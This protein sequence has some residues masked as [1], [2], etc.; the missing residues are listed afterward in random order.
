[1]SS[2]LVVTIDTAAPGAPVISTFGDDTGVQGDALT[3]DTTITLS[4]SSEPNSMVSVFDGATLLGTAVA[5][6][7]GAWSY[8]T[9]ALPDG[10]HVFS[11]KATDAAG[12]QSGSSQ[13]FSVRIDSVAPAAPSTPTVSATLNAE[14]FWVEGVAEAGALVIVARGNSVLGS[15]QLAPGQ[16]AYSIPVPLAQETVNLL[17]VTA[18]DAAGN[19]SVATRV[20]VTEVPSLP[21]IF[22]VTSESDAD[23]GLYHRGT[24]RW[25]INQANASAG[26][27]IIRFNI[28]GGGVRTITPATALPVLEGGITIDGYSQP[29][30]SANTANIDEAFNGVIA[31][32][33]AGGNFSTLQLNGQNYSVS[34]LALGGVTGGNGIIW[35]RGSGIAVSGNFIGLGADGAPWGPMSNYGVFVSGGYNTIGGSVPAQRNIVGNNQQGVGVSAGESTRITGNFIGVGPSGTVSRPNGMGIYVFGNASKTI[36]GTNSDG[37]DDIQERN[38]V[39]GNT[40]MGI[41]V[42][43]SN[44]S[45]I[46]GN[47][48]GLTIKGTAALANGFWGIG[49][50][51]AVSATV[52]SNIVSGNAQGGIYVRGA[53]SSTNI[54][55]QNIV[56]LAAD[57][58]TALGNAYSGITLNDWGVAGDGPSDTQVVGNIVASNREYG[59]WTRGAKNSIIRGNKV[60][61]DATGLK[62]SGNTSIGVSVENSTGTMIGGV[63]EADGNLISG[64]NSGGIYVVS[65]SNTT[66]SANKVGTNRDGNAK[67]ANAAWGIGV[68]NSPN[69]VIGGATASLGNLVSGNSQGGIF[70]RGAT[71]TSVSIRNNL[72]GTA[73]NGASALGNAFSGIAIVD[74][75]VAND[76]PSGVI[77]SENT[78]SAN[79]QYGIWIDGVS[80]TGNSITRN[81]VGVT[82]DGAGALSN[83]S[84]AIYINQSSGNSIGGTS[85]IEGNT[86]SANGWN[87]ILVAG[88]SASGNLVSGNTITTSGASGVFVDSAVGTS[89]RLNTIEAPGYSGVRLIGATGGSQVSSNTIRNAG[90]GVSISGSTT[91]GLSVEGNQISQVATG[92]S[93]A[94]GSGISVFGNSLG[95]V[96]ATG[97]LFSSVKSGSSV[98]HNS[99]NGI[100]GKGIVLENSSSVGVSGNNLSAIASTGIVISG[101]SGVELSASPGDYAIDILSSSLSGS[102]A[103][104][105]SG[106][107]YLSAPLGNLVSFSTGVT[108][109]SA[110]VVRVSGAI[111]STSG[112][113]ILGDGDT[114]VVLEGDTA[115]DSGTAATILGGAVDGAYSLTIAGSGANQIVSQ[116]GAVV[117]LAAFTTGATGTISVSGII[118]TGNIVLGNHATVSGAIS[119]N[120]GGFTAKAGLSAPND[121]RINSPAGTIVLE[122]KVAVAGRAAFKAG[123]SVT[124]NNTANQF[125]D[126][127]TVTAPSVT[128]AA[129]GSISAEL[130]ATNATI[131]SGSNAIVA[132]SVSGNLDVTASGAINQ[133]GPLSVGQRAV[134]SARST[135]DIRLD[136]ANNFQTLAVTQ[137]RNV[138]VRD[139][140]AITLGASFIAG[141]LSVSAGGAVSADALKVGG[142]ASFT[143][144]GTGS[145]SLL[146]ANDFASLEFSVGGDVTV[147]DVN[148][149][150]LVGG[151][152]GGNLDVESAGWLSDSGLVTV[153]GNASLATGSMKLANFAVAGAVGIQSKGQA[154]VQNATSLTVSSAS[155]LGDL[156][157]VAITGNISNQGPVTVSGNARLA[158][159]SP[160]GTI[161]LNQV[162]V[163]GSVAF[164]SAG[165]VFLQSS[166]PIQL[167]ESIIAGNLAVEGGDSIIQGGSL[168]VTGTSK[169]SAPGKSV[170]LFDSGNDFRGMVTVTAGPVAILASGDLNLMLSTGSATVDAGGKLV[171]RGAV[172]GALSSKSAGELAQSGPLVV[173]ADATITA[174]G[175]SVTLID[176]GN[177][178]RGLVTVTAGP[179]AIRGSGDLNLSLS[180]GSATVDAGGKL[181]IRGVVSGALSSKSTG[182]VSQSG[183]LVVTGDA[184]ITAPSQSVSLFDSGNDFRGMVTVTAGPVGI[185]ASG[186]LNVSL[187]TGSATVDAGGKLVIRGVVSGALSSKSAGPVSQSGPLMVT[188]DATITAPGKSV[189]LNNTGNDFQGLTSV[190]AGNVEIIDSNSLNVVVNASR[191]DLHAFGNLQLTG[192]VGGDLFVSNGVGSSTSVG[193]LFVGG[194]MDLKSSGHVSN[195]GPVTI[196][197]SAMVRIGAQGNLSLS[198]FNRF[199]FLNI[200][201][202]NQVLVSGAML[203]GLTVSSASSVTLSGNSVT[204]S[205]GVGIEVVSAGA[206]I[207]SGNLVTGSAKSGIVVANSA[208]VDV[209]DNAVDFSGADGIALQASPGS[210]VRGNTVTKAGGM[211]IRLSGISGATVSGNTIVSPGLDGISLPG[212]DQPNRL[213]GNTFKGISPGRLFVDVGAAG[214]DSY[215]LTSLANPPVLSS[216]VSDVQGIIVSGT[217]LGRPNTATTI[218]LFRTGAGGAAEPSGALTGATDSLGV[219]TFELVV[220]GG[221]QGNGFRAIATSPTQSSEMSPELLDGK[222]LAVAVRDGA[223]Q[224]VMTNEPY[225]GAVRFVV[226]DPAGSVVPFVPVRLTLPAAG[227]SSAFGDGATLVRGIYGVR[228]AFVVSDAAGVATAPSIKAGPVAGDFA[229]TAMVGQGGGVMTTAGLEIRPPAPLV[230][231]AVVPG[232]NLSDPTAISGE[233]YPGSLVRIYRAGSGALVASSQLSLGQSSFS[234]TLPVAAENDRGERWIVTATYDGS[235]AN[236]SDQTAGNESNSRPIAEAPFREL[237]LNAAS[238]PV[239]GAVS[240]GASVAISRNTKALTATSA[241]YL[242]VATDFATGAG[243]WTS[244][245]GGGVVH[246]GADQVDDGSLSMLASAP[247]GPRYFAAPAAYLGNK[248]AFLGGSLSFSL[249]SSVPGAGPVDVIIQGAG[250]T[251][252]RVVGVQPGVSWRNYSASFLPDGTWRVGESNGQAATRDQ[253]ALVLGSLESLLIRGTDDAGMA[254]FGLDSVAMEGPGAVAY[255]LSLDLVRNTKNQFV[256]VETNRFGNISGTTIL[257]LV[258]EDSIAPRSPAFVSVEG[259]SNVKGDQVLNKNRL[260]L[261]AAADP[262]A[263]PLALASM[264]QAIRIFR[265]GVQVGMVTA[266]TDGSWSFSDPATLPDGVYSYSATATDRAGNE[267]VRSLV[268]KVVVD[269]ANPRS[270]SNFSITPDTGLVGDSVTSVAAP[271]FSG[272][273]EPGS[274]VEVFE[275]QVFLGS[276]LADTRGRW[277]ID[278][279]SLGNGVHVVAV[280]STDLAGNPSDMAFHTIVID[281]SGPA[282]ASIGKII[283]DS[284][285]DSSDGVTNVRRLTLEGTGEPGSFISLTRNGSRFGQAVV[286]TDGIWRFDATSTEL[287]DGTHAFVAMAS[288]LA[289]NQSEATQVFTAVVDTRAPL[290]PRASGITPDTGNPTDRIT[291]VANPVAQGSAEPNARVL[292]FLNSQ[293]IGTARADSLG[294]WSFQLPVLDPGTYSVS[295]RAIDRAGNAS[296]DSLP[297]PVTI[298]SALPA[299][300][301]IT[302][303]S[304]DTG[305]SA[306]DLI[307]RATGFSILGTSTPSLS[308][309]VYRGDTLLG[310]TKATEAGTF[311]LTVSGLAQG[312][313]QFSAESVN[314]AGTNSGRGGALGVRVDTTAPGTPFAIFISDDLGASLSDLLTSDNTLLLGG[315]S[316]SGALVEVQFAGQVRRALADENGKFRVSFED[317]ALADGSYP[318]QILAFDVAG[319]RSARAGAATIRIDTGA[320]ALAVARLETDT[321]TSATDYITSDTTPTLIGTAEAGALVV[322]KIA[323]VNICSPVVADAR[324][325]WVLP[326]GELLSGTYNLQIVATDAAGNSTTANVSLVIDAVS[327]PNATAF[328]IS[329][330]T[331]KPGDFT[332]SSGDVVLSGNAESGALIHVK[333]NGVSQPF[334]AASANSDWSIGIRL[335]VEGDN[336]IWVSVIDA[337]GN[338]CDASSFLVKRDSLAPLAP[339]LSRIS[340]D[341]GFSDTDRVTSA[342]VVTISG[343]A[344]SLSLVSITLN[345]FEVGSTAAAGDGA[346]SF[347]LPSLAASG[348]YA[349]AV[350][351][352]DAAGNLSPLTTFSIVRDA[353]APATAGIDGILDGNILDADGLTANSAPTIRG[354]AEPFARVL[355]AIDNGSFN[356]TTANGDGIWSVV[357]GS[358]ADGIHSVVA[359]VE[360]AAGNRAELS[361]PYFFTIDTSPPVP[362]GIDSVSP[363]HGFSADDG[364]ISS[365]LITVSGHAE[366]GSRLRVRFG[367]FAV[368]D[369][370][371]PADGKWRADFQGMPDGTY[372]LEALTVDIAGNLA[373]AGARAVKVDT[374]APSAPGGL[375][376]DTDTGISTSDGVTRIRPSFLSGKGEAGAR[377]MVS[378]PSLGAEWSSIIGSD[379][380]WKAPI[381]DLPE[382]STTFLIQQTD[383]AGNSSAIANFVVTIDSTVPDRPSIAE[384]RGTVN[385]PPVVTGAPLSSSLPLISGR[386]EA[387]A[388]VRVEVR[389]ATALA[390]S[391]TVLSD[392]GGRWL[393]TPPRALADN[394]YSVTVV[395]IDAAGNESEASSAFILVLDTRAPAAPTVSAV[396]PDTGASSTDN[397]TREATRIVGL[398]EAGARVRFFEILPEG[399]HLLLGEAVAGADRKVELSLPGSGLAHGIHQLIAVAV[400]PAGNTGPESAARSVEVDAI[401]PDTPEIVLVSDDSGLA[402]DGVTN[403]TTPSIS[404]FAEPGATVFVRAGGPDAPAKTAVA[405]EDGSWSVTL[406]LA[407]GRH[408]IEIRAVDRAGN[409]SAIPAMRTLVIDKSA[410]A[411]PSALSV[412]PD[413]GRLATDAITSVNR[414]EISGKSEAGSVV[415]VRCVQVATGAGFEFG[416]VTVGESGAWVVAAPGALDDGKYQFEIDSRDLAGNISAKARLTMIID[417]A[418]PL[419]EISFPANT[420]HYNLK[421]WTGAVKGTAQLLNGSAVA[422][423]TVTVSDSLG[424]HYNGS[425]FQDGHASVVATGTALWSLALPASALSTGLSYTVSVV[426][427]DLAGNLDAPRVVSFDFDTE[428]P[429]PALTAQPAPTNLGSQLLLIDFGEPVRSF[430]MER[431]VASEGLKVELASEDMA[432]GKFTL[433]LTPSREGSFGIKLAAGAVLDLAGNAA[434]AIAF[435]SVF[436]ISTAS[437]N[438]QPL[439]FSAG[440]AGWSG[441]FSQPGDQD[442]F[443]ITAPA[444]G[445]LAISLTGAR[446]LG[447]TLRIVDAGGETVAL[448]DNSS[449]PSSSL[450]A[451]V[452]SGQQLFV[453]AETRGVSSGAYT[454]SMS[455]GGLFIDD[456]GDTAPEAGGLV[457]TGVGTFTLRGEINKAG[458][459]DYFRF[460]APATGMITF[461]AT[462]TGSA[463]LVP[464]LAGGVMEAQFT[465]QSEQESRILGEA[466]IRFP[467]VANIAYLVK[468][469]SHAASGVE[470]SGGYLLESTFVAA[471]DEAIDDQS[472]PSRRIDL[473]SSPLAP[474]LSMRLEAAADADGF[475]IALPQSGGRILIAVAAD[476]PAMVVVGT[477]KDARTFTV[478]NGQVLAEGVFGSGK[479]VPVR[480]FTNGQAGGAYSVTAALDERPSTPDEAPV[481]DPGPTGQVISGLAIPLPGDVDFS[482]I[483]ARSNGKVIVRLDPVGE[484]FGAGLQVVSSSG[485]VLGSGGL[486]EDFSLQATATVSA[487]QTVF[488]RVIGANG[489]TGQYRLALRQVPDDFADEVG[490]ATPLSGVSNGTLDYTSDR[491]FFVFTASEAGPHLVRAR[492]VAG[493]RTEP[494]LSVYREGF[495]TPV[496]SVD[497]EAPDANGLVT[498]DLAAGER[499]F[500]E[501]AGLG[502]L[503]RY[504]VQAAPDRV[505]ATDDHPDTINQGRLAGPGSR[506]VAGTATTGVISPESDADYLG[507]SLTESGRYTLSADALAGA[508]LDPRLALFQKDSAGSWHLLAS[509]DDGGEGANALI[510]QAL[511]PGEYLARVA[512]SRGTAGAYRVGLTRFVTQAQTTADDAPDS[513][514]QARAVEFTGI[515]NGEKA[516]VSARIDRGA[517]LDFFSLTPS[518]D[519][520]LVISVAAVSG[521][522]DPVLAY[523]SGSENLTNDNAG[524]GIL[525]SRIL[526]EA[527]AGRPIILSVASFGLTTGAYTL[528]ATVLERPEDDHGQTAA[529]AAILRG[530]SLQGNLEYAGDRDV[531]RYEP[532]F[533]GILTI[534]LNTVSGVAN[535]RL[536]ILDGQGS[537]LAEDVAGGDG[538]NSLL[539]ARVAAGTPLFIESS[540]ALGETG[541]YRLAVDLADDDFGND[542]AGAFALDVAGNASVIQGR[543]NITGNRT[544]GSARPADA[545]WFRFRADRNGLVSFRADSSDGLDPYLFVYN[546]SLDLIGSQD[547]RSATDHGSTVPMNVIEGH[548]YYV[549]IVGS[550]GTAGNYLFEA[551]PV[552]DDFGNSAESSS[553]LTLDQSGEAVVSGAI[554]S[555][556]DRDWFRFTPEADGRVSVRLAAAANSGLDSNLAAFDSAGRLIVANDDS[557]DGTG[558]S[559]VEFSVQ[560]GQSYYLRAQGFGASEGAYELAL[561][562]VAEIGD[563]FG[564]T[565]DMAEGWALDMSGAGTRSGALQSA[566][567]ID[568][569]KVVSPL[570]GMFRI[571]AEV[572]GG[573]AT[574]RVMARKNDDVVQVASATGT[575]TL[576]L[577]AP[578]IEAGEYFVRI[579]SARGD[580]VNYRL[581]ASINEAS[582]GALRPV[583]SDVLSKLSDEFNRG[584]V[585]KISTLGANG[586]ITRIQN[587]ILK[588]LVDSFLLINGVPATNVLIIYLD[589]VDFTVADGSGAQVGRTTNGGAVAENSAASVSSRGALDIVVVPVNNPGSYSM[590]LMGVGGG[591]VLAGATMVTPDGKMITPSVGFNGN[592]YSALPARDVPKEG[593]NLVLDFRQGTG[594]GG[595][596]GGDTGGGGTGGGD[597][598]GGGTAIATAVGAAVNSTLIQ[599]LSGQVVA[600]IDMEGLGE[601]LASQATA[602][603]S[604]LLTA[605][606]IDGAR[607]GK[608][609]DLSANGLLGFLANPAVQ[610]NIRA[611]ATVGQDV[612]TSMVRGARFVGSKVPMVE[613]LVASAASPLT[614]ITGAV[615]PAKVSGALAKAVTGTLVELT[616]Q[617]DS[618]AA[619]LVKAI[620]G[621]ASKF[622]TRPAGG[623]VNPKPMPGARSE[624]PRPDAR[625]LVAAELAGTHPAL[626]EGSRAEI[627]DAVW[628]DVAWMAPVEDKS[629]HDVESAITAGLVV[630]GFMTPGWMRD[631]LA[632]ASR[633]RQPVARLKRREAE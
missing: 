338:P 85:Q 67:I 547:N 14:G 62:A 274:L 225:G 7:D 77:V 421:G 143:T 59:I 73:W 368:S 232:A 22:T 615:V 31:I 166:G 349:V 281:A 130:M 215:S 11:A 28:P 27:D 233:A 566:R 109:S 393:F 491:D 525:D 261:V 434:P 208:S 210:L 574:I 298:D 630:T 592:N 2:A 396:G 441:V 435:N 30:A 212:T 584:F 623:A 530:D 341:T 376:I 196:L 33:I 410:P 419:A 255:G 68:R 263:H 564:D 400:D 115:I 541:S 262:N 316:E 601:A 254:S 296:P 169:I 56:G 329:P 303:I 384:A 29:G 175:K 302:A 366:P 229:I 332:T 473:V 362:P 629:G 213:A 606:T 431:V 179:V 560:A 20:T 149:L 75:G 119:S 588:D 542:P 1:M 60:G 496:M 300:P 192:S 170:T 453:V 360:D 25:A 121:L 18:T 319:N 89:V 34:G 146:A 80:S 597:T 486:N 451:N 243:G 512:A 602:L 57:G 522:L 325:G 571:S 97:I 481:F 123:V 334:V 364:V 449:S 92:I 21:V 464:S 420:G 279:P 239:S 161:S 306:T 331:G 24:L 479:T 554:N 523:S 285:E 432:S 324:G 476:F 459:V 128:L 438:A 276:A 140:N 377:V 323:G 589:P 101:S 258:T 478:A 565:V 493:E 186:D 195:S 259:D 70:V 358:L 395:A 131:S 363:D 9:I 199:G 426:A 583:D 214:M 488:A 147:R 425:E 157:L 264:S 359:R 249:R 299:T 490:Q 591:R 173:T 550:A 74:W 411:M 612:A 207:V 95:A 72:V 414:P 168:L 407:E 553:P 270:P 497:A 154:L 81:K 269:T 397:L 291:S 370:T 284:G 190:D 534:K 577:S 415:S 110:S 202:D 5:N 460:V 39:S 252:A 90:A 309:L 45:I 108:V 345:G 142:L 46:S 76:A 506:I 484:V 495:A 65:S 116:A 455:L 176:S 172:S 218:E 402:G 379:G 618:T 498:L 351:A 470:A 446:G 88:A 310:Q 82:R 136:D 317:M 198:G 631:Q 557:S 188:G 8:T 224:S 380:A 135:D 86:V 369:S 159:R 26:T 201:S 603:A 409:S 413:T 272:Q 499:I 178:F 344:E 156:E 544:D 458:D 567:D 532:A 98:R 103:I 539:T 127:V 164:T 356:S 462:P 153:A 158:T 260:T 477:G 289:G 440:Q 313:Y 519:G 294:A 111:S 582:T 187:S 482:G 246:V 273:A 614:A 217:Y 339:V 102:T 508:K 388:R 511:E 586:D 71:S 520:S 483:V 197:G 469:G 78:V 288:D 515:P 445:G 105:S 444:T 378:I 418:A 457:A 412:S 355:V 117:P 58:A 572:D 371:V 305:S 150:Q 399:G 113:I 375:A 66:I 40:G 36:V 219:M 245:P 51:N 632:G 518:K 607:D 386:A 69:T 91:S 167:A 474:E 216:V 6:R 417:T 99:L 247:S 37:I 79:G 394:S 433:A 114:P 587:E 551:R 141:S 381:G 129:G 624:A 616:R 526:V 335:P 343:L 226:T 311:S 625:D 124:A 171:I 223:G 465:T 529:S 510:F 222:S 84:I 266:A 576:S 104:S 463:T 585:Q 361:S 50:V 112:S 622:S 15:Q 346:W 4:G 545:D 563:E 228:D 352:T 471:G 280:R 177:D 283:E 180:A 41:Y 330:D 206:V 181:V 540:S 504:T 633:P 204:S 165:D 521:G 240:A 292:V 126:V 134:F 277:G 49:L 44:G 189:S 569:L 416:T 552:V 472:G 328:S 227:V 568:L 595:T 322:A 467:V 308:V 387:G 593:L 148:D 570:S 610:A 619:A 559:V 96:S 422:R 297:M 235:L 513:A 251:L 546:S 537:T 468:V 485:A 106:A 350:R 94:G 475:D 265:D 502:R 287:L 507:F 230:L 398:A 203:G 312:D 549:R 581:A 19:V 598:G 385:A 184:T 47:Y 503:G 144:G 155:A 599:A 403:D 408:L 604:L 575:G 256:L 367:N 282:K 466:I 620:G 132:G 357:P 93:V 125:G 514:T 320:P 517:D 492:A 83:S 241:P 611:V 578:V 353:L 528:T 321:G 152:A 480:I 617:A 193:N 200:A 278:L 608:D 185:R 447:T 304:N 340:P 238:I 556:F 579:E 120:Q 524:P 487:G 391:G 509:D 267:S 64:N 626:L 137:A 162:A 406:S 53:S 594:G 427:E 501:V 100:S 536:R 318:A 307:T 580:L 268:F 372:L 489:S 605:A 365:S 516:V 621:Q 236:L 500:I 461:T 590:N 326:L 205:A 327:P 151:A 38:V 250:L 401:A 220:R 430:P 231:N 23:S 63:L 555:A 163:A 392:D 43:G 17:D 42:S 337:A 423:V 562:P 242:L 609:I 35:V 133:S 253:L 183:P 347:V 383:P 456:F 244:R 237:Y 257:P 55:S 527:V 174:P 450:R 87:G 138:V 354:R 429:V 494:F 275:G 211:A 61:T 538:L 248:S 627:N 390:S 436:D 382:G 628:G 160:S 12:N 16:T 10:V 139:T 54:V 271:R 558:D 48:A 535:P 561:T 428:A 439:Q 295:A 424:R 342:E 374:L 600:A 13:G 405:A 290:A 452:T 301:S 533:A 573:D 373:S 389:S 596:G 293:P 145:L 404:G 52:S 333:V 314:A 194:G 505:A 3:Y 437:S 221:A 32:Q 336:K 443:R 543:I 448:A 442:W 118:S 531:F 107:V 454:L 122:G 234:I 286:G 182:P 348:S 209:R 315:M 548:T 191:L 613:K